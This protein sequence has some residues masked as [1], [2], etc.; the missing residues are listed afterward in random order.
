MRFALSVAALLA[1]ASSAIAQT[2][3]FLPLTKPTSGEKVPAGSTYLVEWT[4]PTN[5]KYVA[6]TVTI[7]LIGGNDP[8]TLV[9]LGDIASEFPLQSWKN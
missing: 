8:K 6:G 4:I 5:P 7:G 2:A 3:D 9:P 1:I